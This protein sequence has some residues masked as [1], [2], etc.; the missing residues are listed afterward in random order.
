MCVVLSTKKGHFMVKKIEY[1]LSDWQN[2]IKYKN[3]IDVNKITK[4]KY[5]YRL[6]LTII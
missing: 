1:F 5:L 3:D 6:I 4:Y 2:K